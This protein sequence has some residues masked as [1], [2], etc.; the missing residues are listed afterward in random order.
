MSGLDAFGVAPGSTNVGPGRP[1]GAPSPGPLF[2][3]HALTR[4]L[5]V[6]SNTMS[7]LPLI[8]TVL[9]LLH[10]RGS[11]DFEVFERGKAVL[12]LAVLRR[13]SP[14]PE[15]VGSRVMSGRTCT[16]PHAV[17]SRVWLRTTRVLP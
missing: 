12:P 3:S 17:T 8:C 10:T 4:A 9:L 11:E 6:A 5:A 16:L 15:R 14:L 13:L 7:I 1:H 2:K